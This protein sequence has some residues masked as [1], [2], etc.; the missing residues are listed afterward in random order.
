MDDQQCTC[1]FRD[2]RLDK[3]RVDVVGVR[4]DVD[5]D[6]RSA[7]VADAVGVAMYE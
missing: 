5:E 1:L 2:R 3:S 6:R 4:L 7:A